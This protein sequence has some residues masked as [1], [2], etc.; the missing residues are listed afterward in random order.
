MFGKRFVVL[1]ETDENARLKEATVKRMVS[2]DEVTARGLYKS[3]PESVKPSWVVVMVTN[4]MPLIT[5]D[6]EG[7]H[8]RIAVVPPQF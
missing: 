1:P 2:R 5:G 6:D 4:Y 3:R 8:R 7:I